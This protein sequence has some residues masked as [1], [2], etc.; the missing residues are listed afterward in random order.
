MA[1]RGLEP[2]KRAALLTL[3]CQRG[4][5][6]PAFASRA[7]L[8]EQCEQR[9]MVEKI[10]TLADAFRAAGLPVVHN[11]LVHRADYGGTGV[12]APLLGANFKARKMIVGTPHV[13]LDPRLRAQPSDYEVERF[14]GVT[15]F[16]ATPLEILLRNCGVTTVIITGVSTNLGVPGAAIEAINRNFSVIFPEDCTAGVW[17]EA[18]EFHVVN[19]LPILGV[20][21]TSE[22]VIEALQAGG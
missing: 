15:P 8:S 6:D 2:G 18:H 14:T 17:P 9:R 12:N 1:L 5:I 21:T 16:H 7:G 19:T 3:E 20:V 11:K 4:V 10:A 13:D 22:A